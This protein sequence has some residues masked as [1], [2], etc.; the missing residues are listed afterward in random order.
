MMGDP[1]SQNRIGTGTREWS[2]LSYN[3]GI[4]CSHDCLYCYARANAVDRWKSVKADE[5]TTEKIRQSAVD[6]NWAR[7]IGVIM[8]PTTHD[9]TLEYLQSSIIVLKKMLTAGNHVLIVSKPHFECIIALC[10]ELSEWKSQILFRFTIGSMDATVS[11]L[12]EPGAPVPYERVRCLKHAYTTGYSTSVSVEPNLGGTLNAT[13]V[14]EAVE[15]YVTHDIW[16]GKMNKIDSRVHA[17]NQ[18]M[19]DAIERIR[20]AQCDESTLLL[21]NHLRYYPKVAWKD[22]IKQVIERSARLGRV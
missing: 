13:D 21:Y 17:D 8:Y 4:G 12:W 5:W 14:V 10:K 2:D 15:D 18:E 3:I 9:I 22:S 20:V 7:H 6:K 1:F 16:I 11:H 19:V